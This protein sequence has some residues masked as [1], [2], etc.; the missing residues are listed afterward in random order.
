MTSNDVSNAM[1]VR[2]ECQTEQYLSCDSAI[3][4]STA[5]TGTAP[6]TSKRSSTAV[7]RRGIGGR[8]VRGQVGAQGAQRMASAREDE[9]DVRA[10]A[11]R[12]CEAQR[13]HRR[14]RG[15]SV[16]VERDPVA[17]DGAGEAQVAVPDEVELE[18]RTRRVVR[19]G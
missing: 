10:H 12:E 8:A 14:D 18:R 1:S 13:L 7:T 15:P 19:H 3:A 9:R 2:S 6:S 4:R 17:A 16:A 5:S 11:R